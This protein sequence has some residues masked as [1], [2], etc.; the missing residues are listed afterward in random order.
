MATASNPPPKYTVAGQIAQGGMGAILRVTDAAIGRTVAMKVMLERVQG[1][2]EAR[3][4]FLREAQVLGQLEHPNIVPMHE[5]GANEQGQPYYTMKLVKGRTLQQVFTGLRDGDAETVREFPL[6]HLLTIFQK[7]CD[8][9]AYAH[10]KGVVH[11]DLKPEN[12]M[13]GKFGEVLVMDWGLAKVLG[14]RS[15]TSE[16]GGPSAVVTTEVAEPVVT[17]DGDFGQTLEGTVLG[18][19]Q[20]M[21]PEQAAGRLAEIDGRTDVF[22]LGGILY[23]LLTLRAP[24]G[25]SSLA[26]VL[27]NVRSGYLAPPVIYNTAR[28]RKA[29]GTEGEQTIEL[30][31]CPGG[32]VPE[33]LSMVTMRAMA[34]DPAQRYQTVPEL[35]AELTKFQGGFATRAE[36]AGYGRRFVLWIKRNKALSVSVVVAVTVVV[37]FVAAV[38]GRILSSERAARAALADLRGLLPT[39]EKEVQNLT[40][41]QQFATALDRL[42]YMLALAPGNAD[43]LNLKGNV[44]QSLL[45]LNQAAKAYEEAL[46]A[47]SDL[48]Y[49]EENL[50]LS[51]RLADEVGVSKAPE[52]R[53]LLELEAAMSRQKRYVESLAMGK[54]AGENRPARLEAY[55]ALLRKAPGWEQNADKLEMDDKGLLQFSSVLVGVDDLTPIQGMPF[56]SLALERGRLVDLSPLREMPL[57]GL[58]LTHI[59]VVDL[60]PLR[61][62]RQGLYL[63]GTR[64]DDLRPLEGM[65]LTFLCID[66]APISDLAPL[67][68]M[69][70]KEL[71]LPG[72]G[73]VADLQP[74][75]GL[76]LRNLNLTQTRVSDLTPLKG[77]PLKRLELG[78]TKITDLNPLIGMR[79]EFLRFEF[80]GVSDFEPLR[81]MP[82][83]ILYLQGCNKLTDVSPLTDCSSLEEISVPPSV[84]NLDALRGL[85]NLRKIAYI[86]PRLEDASNWDKIPPASEFW[87]AY[88]A[89]KGKK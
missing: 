15:E 77:M 80:T 43:Y 35:Q 7:V 26:E 47:R 13:L 19:P 65:P 3:E 30:P 23:S 61:G 63:V 58:N 32:Q 50:K 48:P 73:K 62:L 14:E 28:R 22:A 89:R 25:G 41:D 72:C 71:M 39:L 51:R 87:K 55:K 11:R 83:K 27:G 57:T 8:A 44:L 20:F 6:S 70:L 60:S 29:D 24:T 45:R 34:L 78:H 69:P 40:R 12:L 66:A 42:N 38:M 81:G 86:G 16:D 31:H 36:Q 54:R 10:A 37:S 64:V 1:D 18:T 59:P 52:T 46:K 4:R 49:A 79:L 9:I 84:R 85:S 67:R 5:L 17:S 76:P 33:A 88:D 21:A 74:L 2:A 68:G 82:L 53:H 75:S 56:G